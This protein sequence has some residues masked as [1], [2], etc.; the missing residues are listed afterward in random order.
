MQARKIGLL[1]VLLS[2]SL[3]SNFA[4]LKVN[5]FKTEPLSYDEWEKDCKAEELDWLRAY[6]QWHI[7]NR[8]IKRSV[9]SYSDD[10]LVAA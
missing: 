8:Y 5:P 6:A 9:Q 1:L 10:R 2:F 7:V 3:R 4:E